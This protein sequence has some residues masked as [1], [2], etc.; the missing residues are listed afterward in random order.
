[1]DR[2]QYLIIGGSTKC[3]TT[4]LFNYFEFHPG[5]CACSMKESRYFLEPEYKLI[6][7]KPRLRPKPHRMMPNALP[8]W[9][10]LNKMLLHKTPH[11]AK[12]QS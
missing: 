5:V 4:S 6:A 9:P 1:M 8:K 3:G 12:P 11:S 2:N 10:P 7:Q